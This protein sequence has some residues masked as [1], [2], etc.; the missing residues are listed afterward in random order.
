MR[1]EFYLEANKVTDA[2]LQSVTFLQYLRTVHPQYSLVACSTGTAPSNSIQCHQR[3]VPRPVLTTAIWDRL[4]HLLQM[5]T[6]PGC[7]SSLASSTALQLHWPKDCNAGCLPRR[8][9]HSRRPSRKPLQW[10]LLTRQ[11]ER[12]ANQRVQPYQRRQ[13]QSITRAW[14]TTRGMVI[15]FIGFK[16]CSPSVPNCNH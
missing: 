16:W 1:F 13:N 7:Y 14:R 2:D 5:G 9:S 10:T 4:Q 11:P 3:L 15:R 8:N 12:R 6:S